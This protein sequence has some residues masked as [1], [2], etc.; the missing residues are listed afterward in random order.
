VREEA[1]TERL[2]VAAEVT[3]DKAVTY[4]WQR[5]SGSWVTAPGTATDATYDLP[6]NLA[7]GTHFFRAVVRSDDAVNVFSNVVT[8][9]VL[10]KDDTET[11]I[12]EIETVRARPGATS[13]EVPVT[14]QNPG[15]IPIG[16]IAL[17]FVIPDGLTLVGFENFPNS[18][19]QIAPG[20]FWPLFTTNTSDVDTARIVLG[21]IR[22]GNAPYTGGNL[23]T[24][25]FDICPVLSETI[26][27]FEVSLN[28]DG[29][30]TGIS[31]NAAP[32]V[33]TFTS[34]GID[35]QR[36]RR[37][38]IAGDGTLP[39]IGPWDMEH[40][41][42]YLADPAS[43]IFPYSPAMHIASGGN[44]PAVGP[45]DMEYLAGY[46]ADPTNPAFSMD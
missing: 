43:L 37:G 19:N 5:L 6:A 32:R 21:S 44:L 38:F 11:I 27:S 7:T 36:F 22:P 45:W 35:I 40:L 34:G 28:I 25:V 26:G 30:A 1:I 10:D 17:E 31:A 46:L 14:L 16:A 41:A 9:G 12:V 15:D 39:S 8:V 24:L 18:I 23:V 2:S 4:E 20:I 42:E 33:Y 3:G 13:V 29:L